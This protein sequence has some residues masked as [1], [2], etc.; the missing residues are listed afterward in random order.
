MGERRGQGVIELEPESRVRTESRSGGSQ[1]AS[2]IVSKDMNAPA[3]GRVRQENPS[4]VLTS[5]TEGRLRSGMSS[6]VAVPTNESRVRSNDSVRMGGGTNKY[7]PSLHDHITR[8][9]TPA[10]DRSSKRNSPVESISTALSS[11]HISKPKKTLDNPFQENVGASN[12]FGDDFETEHMENNPFTDEYDETK[13]P[14]AEVSPVTQSPDKNPF[15]KGDY[16]SQLN[17]FGDN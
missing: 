2:D 14:F 6:S 8:S 4:A 3:E 10:S 16:D 9:S 7:S 15:A 17:P 11:T 1:F 13:N 12:P 5:P